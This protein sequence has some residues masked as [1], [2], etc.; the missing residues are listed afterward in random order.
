MKRSMSG[1]LTVRLPAPAMRLIRARA[2]ERGVTPSQLVR[3]VMEREVGA[4]GGEASA[5]ELTSKWVGS[6]RSSETRPGRSAR[7]ALNDW[8]PDRRG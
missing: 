4:T 7:E 5:Y 1:S 2:R 6:V 3:E 8:R